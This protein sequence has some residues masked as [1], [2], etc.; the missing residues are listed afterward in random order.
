MARAVTKPGFT[1]VFDEV[2]DHP[3]LSLLAVNIVCYMERKAQDG[4]WS[5]GMQMLADLLKSSKS[6]VQREIGNLEKA[7]FL[8]VA[9]SAVG[10][11]FTYRLLRVQNKASHTGTVGETKSV[12][13]RDGPSHP[14]TL[15][16]HPGTR[17]RLRPSESKKKEPPNLPAG[18]ME[19]E[20]FL[21]QSLEE[22][23]E[24]TLVERVT[25]I[26]RSLPPCTDA[27]T[28]QREAENAIKDAGMSCVRECRMFY[29]DGSPGRIDLFVVDAGAR[30]GIELDRRSPRERSVTKLSTINGFRMI[31]LR[32]GYDEPPPEGIDCVIGLAKPSSPV[33]PELRETATALFYGSKVP[34]TQ[35]RYFNPLVND[36]ALL[37]ATPAEVRRR[38][39]HWKVKFPDATCTLRSLVKHWGVLE[40]PP[41]NPYDLWAGK[42][43]TVPPRDED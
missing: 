41:L 20:T 23:M 26:M 27:E 3:D 31:V 14:G 2:M 4:R 39:K 29:P 25:K 36:L 40:P 12:P 38:H 17:K 9:D 32:D 10:Q 7:G 13:P 8:A 34:S 21:S 42:P 33:S 35:L 5:G 43:P 1:M 19:R 16:S 18:G 28:L 6:Q 11:R 15:A 30:L 37:S 24:S 22:K